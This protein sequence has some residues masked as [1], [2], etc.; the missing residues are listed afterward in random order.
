MDVKALYPS[1]PRKEARIAARKALDKR[2]DPITDTD[3]ILEMMDFVLNNNGFQFNDKNYVQIEGTAIG[4]KLGRNYA[5]T[6]MGDW[7]EELLYITPKKPLIFLRYIDDVWGI[8]QHSQGELKEFQEL[9]NSINNNIKVT[10]RS[11]TTMIEFLDVLTKIEDKK[12]T[13]DLFEKDTN[14]HAYLHNKSSHPEHVKKSIPYNLTRRIKNI[15]SKEDDYR[16][17]RNDIQNHLIARGY[18][19]NDIERQQQKIDNISSKDSLPKQSQHDNKTKIPLLIN[20]SKSLPKLNA[21]IKKNAKL[22]KNNSKFDELI[23]R[24]IIAY[25]RNENLK[26]KLVHRKHNNQFF[27]HDNGT[28]RCKKG[29]RICNNIK[30]G[31]EF[32]DEKFKYYTKGNIS[33]DTYNIIYGIFCKKCRRIVYVG[34]TGNN[35]RIRHSLTISRIKT[36][37]NL[38]PLSTHFRNNGHSSGDLQIFGIEKINNEDLYRKTKE[39]FWINKLNTLQPNGINTKT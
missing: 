4:S 8:W 28:Y 25:K 7:E 19:Q 1:V 38:D 29:C 13:T 32:G 20:F 15:C 5:C 36:G 14:S 9:A 2:S 17:R 30:E 33:C 37:R 10:L 12:I 39:Q 26:D 18:K 16:R 22:V 3:T 23:E 31:K 35:I 21:I 11:S 34:E 24:T 6:Y 27:K